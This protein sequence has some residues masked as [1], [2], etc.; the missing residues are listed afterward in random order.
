MLEIFILPWFMDIQNQ[1]ERTEKKCI[2]RQCL[3]KQPSLWVEQTTGRI[4]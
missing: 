2:S 1:L 4:F 3:F